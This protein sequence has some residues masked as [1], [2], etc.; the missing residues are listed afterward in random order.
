[1]AIFKPK[2]VHIVVPALASSLGWCPSPNHCLSPEWQ[3]W[4]R[5]QDDL[6]AVLFAGHLPSRLFSLLESKD[7][8]DGIWLTQD[9]FKSSWDG[10]VLTII[11]T[12][13]LTIFGRGWTAAKS[14]SESAVTKPKNIQK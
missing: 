13:S 4:R 9:S 2:K 11:K 10:L 1:V 12:S 5:H 6:P 7:R 8:A 3:Q 14:A